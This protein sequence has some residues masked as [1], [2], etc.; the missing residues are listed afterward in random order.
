MGLIFFLLTFRLL[1]T[2]LSRLTTSG[3][4]ASYFSHSFSLSSS[5]SSSYSSSFSSSYSSISTPTM[6]F[7]G[8]AQ[9]GLLSYL[10]LVVERSVDGRPFLLVDKL[11]FFFFFFFFILLVKRIRWDREKNIALF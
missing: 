11:F 1:I 5:S 6:A 7:K 2:F 3:N 8:H 4:R 10:L 9:G